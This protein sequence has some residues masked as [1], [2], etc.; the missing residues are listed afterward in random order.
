MRRQ[1]D[2][3]QEAFYLVDRMQDLRDAGVPYEDIAIL[4]RYKAQG[5]YLEKHFAQAGIPYEMYPKQTRT[6]MEKILQDLRD[7]TYAP[8]VQRKDAVSFLTLHASKGL[9]FSYVFILGINDGMLPM[10]GAKYD[11]YE[12]EMRLFYV[13]MTRSKEHLELTY[14][15]NPTMPHAFPGMGKFIKRLPQNLLDFGEDGP[16]LAPAEE[17]QKPAVSL[18][19]LRRMMKEG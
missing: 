19:E 12:E 10:A 8:E 11:A 16:S 9:E 7:G 13:G 14:Y 3:L 4:Y 5:E 1:L 2:P 18:Q 15:E 6:G 17:M